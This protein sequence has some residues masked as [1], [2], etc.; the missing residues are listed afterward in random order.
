MDNV[1]FI[2]PLVNVE[3]G[4]DNTLKSISAIATANDSVIVAGKEAVLS[5]IE[6]ALSGFSLDIQKV[7]SN[8]ENVY[9]IVNDAVME[10]TTEYF[11]VIECGETYAEKWRKN[12]ELYG[13]NCSLIIPLVRNMVE[14]GQ[15]FLSN[16][17][18]WN[19][20]F[21]EEN[22][23]G[24]ITLD[25]LEKYI[26]VSLSGAFFNTED[27]ISAGKFKPSMKIVSWYEFLL[28]FAYKKKKIYV[29][30]KIGVYRPYKTE[31]ENLSKDE[32][33]W[34]ITTARQEYFFTEDRNKKFDGGK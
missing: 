29:V 34:L 15:M 28:R 1:T 25:F 3:G 7:V 10:C 32:V 30:P 21:V 24:A 11:S 18:A 22:E 23:I 19:V 8:G 17:M 6:G 13:Q 31:E 5:E 14:N 12:A 33:E 26:D 2:L 9:S 4:L 27:F 20:A 16:E